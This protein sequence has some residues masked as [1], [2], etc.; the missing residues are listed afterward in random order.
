MDTSTSPTSPTRTLVE[1]RVISLLGKGHPTSVVAAT[2]GITEG[3]VSQIVAQ[4]GVADDISVLRFQ[5][6]A[7]YENIDSTYDE[8]ESKMQEK[9]RKSLPMMI[10][11]DQI[12]KGVQILN[13][14]KRRSPAPVEE[15][16]GAR[17]IVRISVPAA[18]KGKFA[19]AFNSDGQAIQAGDQ[20]LHTASLGELPALAAKQKSLSVASK[21]AQ[22]EL[23]ELT[24]F[25]E[26]KATRLAEEASE[27]VK[28][29]DRIP[30]TEDRFSKSAA[31]QAAF[32]RQAIRA[33]DL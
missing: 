23:S 22:L 18:F 21:A 12:L 27:G 7:K 32:A 5:A 1:E 16:A 28:E 4:P 13:A 26:A 8:L 3:R 30:K 33:E 10:K 6:L 11:P 15:A 25:I 24:E 29:N 14:A 2:L 20:T 9:L 19:V 31:A 17:E